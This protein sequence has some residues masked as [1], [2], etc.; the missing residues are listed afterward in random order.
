[1]QPRPSPISHDP[2]PTDAS[3]TAPPAILPT[4]RGEVT[5]A[6]LAAQVGQTQYR[7]AQLKRAQKAGQPVAPS[8]ILALAA[9]LERH[10]Q[11]ARECA[12]DHEARYWVSGGAR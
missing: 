4:H 8:E 2:Q 5:I 3:T 11:A 12:A 7:L 6:D 9:E 1:M 10:A